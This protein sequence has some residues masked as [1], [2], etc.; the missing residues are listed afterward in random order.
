MK[1]KKRNKRSRARGNRTLGFAMKKHK[2]SGN[3]GGKGMAGTGK[4]G[5]QKKSWVIKYQHPYFGKQ[6]TTSKSTRRKKNNVINLWQICEK[7]KPGE[8]NL[9]DYKILGVGEIKGKYTITAKA[10]S[11]SARERIEKEGGKIIVVGEKEE[12]SEKKE[13]KKDRKK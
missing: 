12:K 6:G 4:R 8:T 7:Y 1:L 11:K 13:A 5:D 10:V 3:R 2:G 9:K